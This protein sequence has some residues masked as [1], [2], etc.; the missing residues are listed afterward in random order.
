MQKE[1]YRKMTNGLRAKPTLA[2]LVVDGNNAIT[3]AIYVAYPCLLLWLLL[4]NGLDA[5]QK[6][7]STQCYPKRFWFLA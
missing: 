5:A 2:R 1:T 7:A 4:H 3:N 6:A